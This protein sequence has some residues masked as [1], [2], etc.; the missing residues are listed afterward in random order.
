LAA[1]S[2]EEARDAFE[3]AVQLLGRAGLPFEAA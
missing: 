2:F 3:D 1:G